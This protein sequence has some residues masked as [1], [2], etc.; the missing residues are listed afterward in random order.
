MVRRGGSIAAQWRSSARS[1]ASSTAGGPRSRCSGATSTSCSRA[2]SGRSSTATRKPAAGSAS[3]ESDCG[4]REL[5]PLALV[6]VGH[7]DPLLEGPALAGRVEEVGAVEAERLLVLGVLRELEDHLAAAGVADDHLPAGLDARHA[8]HLAELD[9]GVSRGQVVADFVIALSRVQLALL[10]RELA[11]AL[12]EAV[13]R[14]VDIDEAGAFGAGVAETVAKAGRRRDVRARSDSDDLVAERELELALDHVE[15]VDLVR[16][17]VGVDRVEL[18]V[19]RE[20]D[21]LELGELGLDDEIAVPAGDRLTFARMDDDRVLDG[22]PAVR[23][24]RMLVEAIRLVV[25]AVPACAEH[26]G[27]ARVRCV[28]VE[29]LDLFGALVRERVH[30]SGRSGDEG[31]RRAS[32]NVA[33]IGTEPERD[34]SAQDVERVDMR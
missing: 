9:V 31:P 12:D 17:D 16:M 10:V 30:D 1:G 23:G 21:Q 29:E 18:G 8:H 22:S 2:A 19:A 7:L 28:D 20:L 11:D 6:R 4:V 34:L 26:V 25:A 5:R 33:R 32:D 3:A 27:E 15:G 24:W 14:R 13:G